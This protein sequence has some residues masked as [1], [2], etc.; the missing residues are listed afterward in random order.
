MLLWNRETGIREGLADQPIGIEIYLPV[1]S[2][3]AVRA[4]GQHGACEIEGDDLDVGRGLS[5]DVWYLR[6]RRFQQRDR[7]LGIDSV[8]QLRGQFDAAVGIRGK[9]LDRV[10]ED[11]AVAD[12][13][14]YVVGRIERSREQANLLDRARHPGGPNEIS[15]LEGL[16][17]HQEN[18]AGKVRQQTRP[19]HADRHACGCYQGGEA[20]GLDTE[21]AENRQYQHDVQQGAHA[22]VDVADQSGIDFLFA[23]G[24]IDEPQ[25]EG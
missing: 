14:L 12:D 17:D 22:R 16:E 4:H 23:E 10:A 18:A 21:E 5:E 13:G 11:F 8:G 20:G 2:I 6:N 7:L 3:V 19:G 1:V 15:H 25:G 9:V 24:A